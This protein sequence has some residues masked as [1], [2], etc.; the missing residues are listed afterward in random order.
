MKKLDIILKISLTLLGTVGGIKGNDIYKTK[1][2]NNTK[3]KIAK[4]EAEKEISVAESDA[5][6]RTEQTNRR[7]QCVSDVV[8]SLTGIFS[9]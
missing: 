9:R 5:K 7:C 1:N 3:L 2:E 4:V 6:R 8:S